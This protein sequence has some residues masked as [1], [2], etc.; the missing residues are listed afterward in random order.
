MDRRQFLSSA[1][2]AAMGL[3]AH[4]SY[5]QATRIRAAIIGIDHSHAI[6]IL[7]VLQTSTDFE[8]VGVCEPDDAI[9]AVYAAA[10]ELAG[11]RWLTMDEVLKD[12][13][14]AMVAIECAV[15][16]L[17]GFAKEAVYAGK[18]IH[19]DKPAGTSLTEWQEIL[20]QSFSKGLLLQMGYMFRYNPGFD[21]IRRAVKEG[22][23]GT[24]HTINASMP[25]GIDNDKRTRNAHHPGGM[26]LELGCH[27]IDVICL[28]MGPPQKVTPFLHHDADIVDLLN[29]NCLAVFEYDSAIATIDTSAM[30]MDA[31]PTR[32]FKISGTLGKMILEPIEPPVLRMWLKEPKGEYPAGTQRIELPDLPRHVADFADFAKCIRGE[33]KF[34]YTVEHDLNTQRAILL[35]SGVTGI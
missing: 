35:A 31:F 23:L 6:D 9:R 11:V 29:D 3:A 22:W 16:R 17:L 18:H 4:H 33:K 8:L 19:L 21:L 26:M 25:T 30:E 1:T 34:D 13:T 27:L 24:I 5:A 2:I 12:P 20:Q 14:I 10:P 28:M 7:K 15:P 32:R